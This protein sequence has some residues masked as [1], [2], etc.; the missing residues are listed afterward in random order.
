M[1]SGSF[2]TPTLRN[3]Q[4]TDSRSGGLELLFANKRSYT[5]S[6]PRQT[7]G[8]PTTVGDLVN[9]LVSDVMVDKRVEMFVVDGAV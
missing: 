6:L 3:A 5:L 1:S 9:H 4:R 7:S 8:H 2:S